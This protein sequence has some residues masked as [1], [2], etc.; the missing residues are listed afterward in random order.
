MGSLKTQAKITITLGIVTLVFG[1]LS[2]LALT[3][4]YHAEHDVS[5]EWNVVRVSAVVFFV[6]IV[7]AL[8]TLGRML[9]GDPGQSIKGNGGIKRS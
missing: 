1:L 8:Y 5:L 9:K 2:H 4:I 7:M 3:D 6:F